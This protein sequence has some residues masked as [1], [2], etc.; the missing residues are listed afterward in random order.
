MLEIDNNP[1]STKPIKE[2][3]MWRDIERRAKK[4]GLPWSGIPPYPIKH[5]GFVNRVALVGAEEGRGKGPG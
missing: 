1:F 5:L 3:Y 2:R 4:Y